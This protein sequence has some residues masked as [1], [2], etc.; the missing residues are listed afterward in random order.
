MRITTDRDE[1]RR[2]LAQRQAS[3]ARRRGIGAGLPAFDEIAPNGTF[4]GGAVHELLWPP[5]SACPNSLALLL[6]RA[7]QKTGGAIAWSDP[8]RELYLPALSAAGIDLRRLVLLRCENPA[9]QLWALC[10]CLRCPGVGATVACVERLGWIE[11]RRLQLAA[12]RGGG[13]GIFMRPYTA[14]AAASYAAATRWLVRPVSGSNRMQRWSVQLL[15]GHGGRTGQVLLLEVDRE[16]RAVRVSAA[17]ADRP[18][19]PAA[20]R[21]VG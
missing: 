9:D 16:T 8:K 19:A 1:L 5:Q 20:A 13:V 6:A 12:E 4:Q 17:L 21:A 18:S 11:A 15:H 10:E 14:Q 7:A 3:P 2:V